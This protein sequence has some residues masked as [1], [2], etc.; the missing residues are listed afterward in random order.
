[1]FPA[2]SCSEWYPLGDSLPR[3]CGCSATS[4]LN[5]AANFGASVPIFALITGNRRTRSRKKVVSALD[6][7][8]LINP[9]FHSLTANRAVSVYLIDELPA[10]KGASCA[11]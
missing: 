9:H 5:C 3:G 1:M 7:Q 11:D 10:S 4:F 8:L 6:G 2:E